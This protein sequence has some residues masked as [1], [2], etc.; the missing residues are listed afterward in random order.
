VE[1]LA[2]VEGRAAGIG[3]EALLELLQTAVHK[4]SDKVS[5]RSVACIACKLCALLPI[6]TVPVT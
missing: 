2:S 5:T 1:C 4:K 6:Q 3:R